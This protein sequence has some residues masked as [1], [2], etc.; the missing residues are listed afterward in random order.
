M[1]LSAWFKH[2]HSHIQMVNIKPEIVSFLYFTAFSDTC[3][4]TA[5]W[6]LFEWE[7]L[8]LFP[9][10]TCP[11]C[12]SCSWQVMAWVLPVSAG[13]A[14]LSPQQSSLSHLSVLPE[15]YARCLMCACAWTSRF[16]TL[17]SLCHICFH[18][19]IML[20]YVHKQSVMMRD[21]PEGWVVYC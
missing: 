20:N 21:I 18:W 9:W 19:Y 4:V 13:T 17:F 16:Q 2:T 15:L 3:H 1:V 12:D 11:W 6:M 5:L 10:V 7:E 14:S 8:F